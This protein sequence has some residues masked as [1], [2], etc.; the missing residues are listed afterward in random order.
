MLSELPLQ[1]RIQLI[2]II[3]FLQPKEDNQFLIKKLTIVN[4]Y[5]KKLFW[6]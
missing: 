5:T 6:N 1:Y 2:K 4:F 3:M